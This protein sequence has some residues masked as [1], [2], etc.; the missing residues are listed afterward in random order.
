[1]PYNKN[2]PRRSKYSTV[3]TNKTR[4]ALKEKAVEYKGGCCCKCGYCKNICAL[5]FHHEDPNEKDFGI[6]SDG[7]HRSWEKIKIEIDKCILVCANCH[8]EIHEAE[9]SIK[10]L[11]QE[12]E[13]KSMQE[14]LK[15]VNKPGS[16]I[17]DCYQCGKKIKVFNSI[18]AERNFCN[19]ECRDLCLNNYGLLS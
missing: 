15:P 19:R 10:V 17:K 16:V 12:N 18:L 6:S 3:Y 7:V 14:A 13:L 2:D 11:K 5:Q 8:A 1:M 9:Y 4:K